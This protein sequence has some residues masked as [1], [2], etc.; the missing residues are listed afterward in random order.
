MLETGL[1][2]PGTKAN[3][4]VLGNA[5]TWKRDA[6]R[7]G[8]PVTSTPTP[9]ARGIIVWPPN[10]QGTRQWGHVA[11]LEEVYPDGRIR[12]SEA[13]WAGRGISERT[14]TPAQYAGLSFV[15]L[16][17]ATPNPQFSSPPAQPGQKREYRVR[18]GDTLWGIAQREL[19]NGNRWREITKGDGSTFTE[20]EARN[21]RVGMSVYLP[22]SYQTG[23]GTPT[24]ITP[25]PVQPADFAKALA[26]V[27]RWEGG[28]VNHPSDPGGATNKGITQN[29]YNAY[30]A[31]KGLP[32]RDVRLITDQEVEDI[33]YTRY[34]M[35]SGSNQLT[36]RLAMVHFDTAVNMGVGG[37]SS[38]LQQA[39][40][41]SSGDEM[42]V[43]RRYLD[44]REAR[45][46]AIVANKPSMGVFLQG[47]LNRLN[48]LRR[49]V[50]AN[51]VSPPPS[52][53]PGV[54]G[55]INWVNFS[56]TV[57]P[58]I[59]VNL[60]NSPRFSD[61]S[62]RNEPNGRRLEFDA[63]TYGET[64]TDMWLGT[65]DARWFKVKGT[66]LWV[67][68]A[69]IDGNAP[70][71]SPMPTGGFTLPRTGGGDV[72]DINTLSLS[73]TGTNLGATYEIG[74][75]KTP[76]YQ[77]NQGYGD[78]DKDEAGWY[79]K[80]LEFTTR[81]VVK[82][83][84][85]WIPDG[86]DAYLHYLDGNGVD[87][88]FSYKKYADED[89]SGQTTLE[90]VLLDAKSAAEKL[91]QQIISEYPTLANQKVTFNITSSAI[92][93]G[94]GVHPDKL[95]YPDT[96]NWK[97]ALG[98]HMVWVSASVTVTPNQPSLYNMD[99][100][101]HAEDKYDFNQGGQRATL[102]LLGVP[103][104]VNGRLEQ[105]GLAHSYMNRSTL[106]VG[107]IWIQGQGFRTLIP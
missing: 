18:S 50:E 62:S 91:Y 66:N 38:L 45:Y 93:A 39:R 26:F 54:N 102:D 42:S 6:E 44:L 100:K 83:L 72:P 67:P 87:H 13:N 52:S 81:N 85:G 21:L 77:Y 22:V 35:P 63:W 19:G 88:E 14:L 20:A 94:A 12:I 97:A 103:D 25:G 48:A 40:Q 27:R 92:A 51:S 4:W 60:R 28:Y 11:F 70:G 79:E 24:P 49:E 65:P 101:L 23:S 58:S 36:S 96:T 34:W 7:A 71:S 82:A 106:S 61:R 31:G 68:S 55:N 78:L 41:S 104:S 107:G 46:R 74:E 9:G 80:G 86:V 1:L 64:G 30:R 33:Y 57:G 73:A 90:N 105:T 95:P 43:V 99:F 2:P 89:R 84:R 75:Q 10:T 37:A 3:G 56:G 17:N 53:T 47:W 15:R 69:F 8:L 16:E 32:A 29:T 76:F 98:S 5:W 59:G